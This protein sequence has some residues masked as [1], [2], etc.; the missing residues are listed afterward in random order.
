MHLLLATG[1]GG[2]AGSPANTLPPTPPSQVFVSP[3]VSFGKFLVTWVEP[4]P[5]V[6]GYEL[7]VAI[8]SNAYQKLGSS[9]VG[10]GINGVTMDLGDSV[11][12]LTPIHLRMRSIRAGQYSQ[13]SVEANTK[14]PLLAPT[15]FE[16]FYNSSGNMEIRWNNRSQYAVTYLI[17]KAEVNAGQVGPYALV[18]EGNAAASANPPINLTSMDANLSE[19]TT[20]RYRIILRTITDSSLPKTVDSIPIPLLPPKNLK[21]VSTPLGALLSWEPV[22]PKAIALE[23]GRGSGLNSSPTMLANIP[24]NSTNYLDTNIISSLYSYKITIHS[25]TRFAT[26]NSVVFVRPISTPL[27]QLSTR[28]LTGLPMNVKALK[29]WG[30]EPSIAAGGSNGVGVTVIPGLGEGWTTKSIP[31]ITSAG[32]LRF[33]LDA[34]GKPHLIYRQLIDGSQSLQSVHHH[35]FNGTNWASEELF[36]TEFALSSSSSGPSVDVALDQNGFVHAAWR[37]DSNPGC[38]VW[39]GTNRTGRWESRQ[40]STYTGINIPRSHR[41]ALGNN[42]TIFI[43]LG[44]LDKLALLTH[45][46]IIDAFE[47]EQVPTGLV[48][49]GIHDSIALQPFGSKLAVFYQRNNEK[50][51]GLYSQ[52]CIIKDQ[53]QWGQPNFITDKSS[54][55]SGATSVYTTSSR[56]GRLVLA[57]NTTGV[58][59]LFIFKAEQ[60]WETIVLQEFAIDSPIHIGFDSSD[61]LWCGIYLGYLPF[62]YSIY[63][64][65]FE[66]SNI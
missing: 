64:W 16:L 46:S 42:D 43:V 38:I 32:E 48:S 22:S 11:P 58:P 61:K 44:L 19:D 17:E 3:V 63:A 45:S 27:T 24:P 51:G 12:E 54:S 39:Y 4:V 2:G 33:L 14:F 41:I 37:T 40:I 66:A 8:G 18:S 25:L 50:P 60:L 47:T 7:E 53:G 49:A 55:S 28:V 13:Y 35:W 30:A 15:Y 57:L 59:T 52:Y 6:D 65:Y 56:S 26:S 5:G 31:E 29:A 36:R 20:Y 9:V 21:V 1:C 62:P 34:Q 23:I 10:A